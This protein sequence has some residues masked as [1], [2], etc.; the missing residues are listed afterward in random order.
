MTQKEQII[1]H[2]KLYQQIT[3]MDALNDY[4]CFRLAARVYDLRK[5]GHLIEE[6]RHEGGYSVYRMAV[7]AGQGSLFG[8]SV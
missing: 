8:G 1:R 3:P 6:E 4:G 5:D 7:P 2:L